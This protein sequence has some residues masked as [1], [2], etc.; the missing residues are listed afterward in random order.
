MQIDTGNKTAF[1]S[2]YRYLITG[3]SKGLT[4]VK[5]IASLHGP[6]PIKKKT[7]AITVT[8]SAMFWAHEVKQMIARFKQTCAENNIKYIRIPSFF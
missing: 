3:D 2:R 5:D 4:R 6:G 7:T 1:G 8:N